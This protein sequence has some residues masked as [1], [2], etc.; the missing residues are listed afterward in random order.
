MKTITTAVTVLPAGHDIF[1]EQATTISIEDEGGGPFVV[2][3]QDGRIGAGKVSMGIEEWPA[4]RA[5][6]E[7]IFES[8]RSLDDAS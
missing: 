4:I 1:S 8:C 5:A 3:E 6:I 7:Q 2:I